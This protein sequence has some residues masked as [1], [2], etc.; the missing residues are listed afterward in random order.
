MI[1]LDIKNAFNSIHRNSILEIM[2]KYNVPNNLELIIFD[3]LRNRK[4]IVSESELMYFNVGVPQG[5][6]LGSTLWLL[7]VNKLLIE[8]K[9]K[10]YKIVVYADDIII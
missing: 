8:S 10:Y 2:D 9:G 4:I 5:S 1:S 6:I 3:Y 7:I